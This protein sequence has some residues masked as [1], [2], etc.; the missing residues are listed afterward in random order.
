MLDELQRRAAAGLQVAG[1]AS[2][3]RRP[4]SACRPPR[5][6]RPTRRR[7][8]ARRCRDNPAAGFRSGPTSRASAILAL[9]PGL[10]L[11]RQ[12]QPDD[13]R[14][15]LRRLDRQA[16]PAA[17]DLE[18]ALAGLAGRA[19]RAA[20]R[21]CAAARPPAARPATRTAPTNRSSSR[22]ARRRRNHCRGRNG[23][24]CWLAPCRGALSR[25]RWAS[26]LIQRN[27]PLARPTSPSATAL[28]VNSS[29]SATGSGLDH[30]P[31]VPGLV[32]A[33][34]ARGRQ[35]DQRH[36]AVE[37]DRP[38]SGPAARKPI[39]RRRAVGQRRR[40]SR[41]RRVRRRAR[42]APAR[43]PARRAARAMPPPVANRGRRAPD[44]RPELP[45]ARF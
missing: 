30:S 9:G 31:S 42:R 28:A 22:R 32:P 8:T 7:R 40:R 6:S 5:P 25:R 34:R 38:L 26:A 27:G 37:L 1:D 4:T 39:R 14:A 23:R 16:A 24:R 18:Q 3:D 29:N 20:A 33:D 36:P 11:R 43:T 13:R 12:G 41:R 45:C 15:A 10:L 21:S 35:P 2:R 44:V 17:A 19:G